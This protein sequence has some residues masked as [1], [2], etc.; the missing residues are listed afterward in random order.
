MNRIEQF[1]RS[2]KSIKLFYYVASVMRMLIP[3]WWL[4]R[5]RYR[6]MQSWWQRDDASEI[7]DRVNFYCRLNPDKII[8]LGDNSQ[9]SSALKRSQGPSSYYFDIQRWLRYFPAKLSLNFFAGDV[10]KNPDCP[11][12]MKA[13]RLDAKQNNAVILN[14]DRP[15]HFLHPRDNIAFEKKMP[16]L[17]FRGDIH[18]KPHRV[19]FFE[20]YFSKESFD[21]GDTSKVT[22]NSDWT[23][24]RINIAKHFE[25]QYILVLEG[26]DVASALQWVMGSNC[27][28]VMAKP[29]VENW[30][31]HSLLEPGKHY[32]EI[33]SDFSDVEEVMNYYLAHPEKGAAIAT[34]SQRW[35]E[36]FYDKKRE[37]IVSLLVLDKYFRAT[38]QYVD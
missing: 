23:K 38:G 3:R 1:Y 25:Y 33:A 4:R 27:V 34:E 24:P 15:R 32:V 29:T 26:N 7:A 2:G 37:K 20:K 10:W 19:A 6:I 22:T 36:Q 9:F 16:K 14:L 8:N 35:Y 18:N 31:M 28:P 5:Q 30:L 11:T 21:L 17:L 13:R 12:F